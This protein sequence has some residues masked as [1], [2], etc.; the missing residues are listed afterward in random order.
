MKIKLWQAD[1]EN[2]L[3]GETQFVF[4]S[5]IL[6]Q[7][8]Y[9]LTKL[10]VKYARCRMLSMWSTYQRKMCLGNGQKVPSSM[11]PM[12]LLPKNANTGL[13]KSS[14]D[15]RNRSR[16]SYKNEKFRKFEVFLYQPNLY[17]AILHD[18]YKIFLRESSKST[19]TSH[20]AIRVTNV[21]GN[22]IIKLTPI[23]TN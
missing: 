4:A 9:F 15:F 14:K 23:L 22:V 10:K 21:F 20:S 12:H 16:C 8:E 19:T 17:K 18:I 3:R 1:F 7:K 2:N 6:T 5:T 13:L 11:F